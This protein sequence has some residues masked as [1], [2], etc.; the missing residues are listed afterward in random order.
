MNY[1]Q[2]LHFEANVRLISQLENDVMRLIQ[3]NDKLEKKNT[4]LILEIELLKTLQDNQIKPN[5]TP[6]SHELMQFTLRKTDYSVDENRER[7]LKENYMAE[8]ASM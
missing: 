5:I 7:I 6:I 4:D 8:K 2:T 3:A 1:I